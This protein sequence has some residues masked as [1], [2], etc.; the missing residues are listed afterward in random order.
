MRR[1]IRCKL[2]PN[3]AAAKALADTCVAFAAA[4]NAALKYGES[5]N[6][7]LHKLCYYDLRRDFGLSANLA[8][9]AI[10]RTAAALTRTKRHGGRTLLFRPTSVDYDARIFDYRERDETVSLTTVSGRRHVPLA[11]GAYQRDA[12]RGRKPGAAILVRNGRDWSINIVVEDEP[13]AP[14]EGPPMGVDLGIRNTAATSH[15]TLHEGSK[16]QTFK[17]ERDRIRA[18][19][20]SKGTP[21]AR[22]CLKRLSGYEARRIRHENHVLSKSIVDEAKRQ[23]NGIIRLERLT[24][25]RQRTRIRSRHFNR[26]MSGWSFGEL[27]TFVAYK[28]QR[29]GIKVEY[30]N[31]RY[32]SQT[33]YQCGQRGWR[34][35]DVFRCTTC[36]DAHADIQAARVIAGGGVVNRL[37]LMSCA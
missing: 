7:K 13:V 2:L 18:S 14:V 3:A 22:R 36:G 11:L 29:T 32:T 19:L 25:I 33:C 17:R 35:G 12:L 31:P 28:A 15:G 30:V 24:G 6:I 1:T 10:R 21:G 27:Q 5:N 9:R 4:C 23:G 16:R 8:A 26:M 34:R 37:E 20:Q